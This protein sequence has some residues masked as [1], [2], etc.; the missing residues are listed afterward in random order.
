[1][2]PSTISQSTRKLAS[3]S[4]LRFLNLAATSVI[5]ILIMPFVVRMLGDRMYGVWALVATMIGYYGVL[6]FGLVQATSR[7]LASALGSGDEDE[8]NRVFNTG[9]RIYLA[10]GALVLLGA[11]VAALLA[12]RLTRTPEDASLFAR[13]IL[14]LGLSLA[15]QFPLRIF[16]GALEGHLRFDRTASLDMLALALRTALTVVVL[17]AGYRVEGLA[18]ST[19]LSYLPSMALTFHFTRRDLPFL[20]FDAKYWKTQTAKVLFSYSAYS[21][22]AQVAN[23]LRFQVDNLVVAGVVGLAA[24]TH[25]SVGGKLARSYMDAMVTLLGTFV[26]VFSRKEGAGD[27]EGLRK[28]FLFATRLSICLS[29]F[30]GFG[31]LVWGRPF[32]ARWMGSS[33]LDGYTCLAALVP[34]LMVALWQSPSTSLMFGI[35]KH[36]FL[37]ISSVIEGL[38]NLGLSIVLARKYGIVGVAL[39]TTFPMLVSKIFIQPFYVC[40]VADIAVIDYLRTVGRTLA[41]VIAAL[42]VPFLLTVK[43]VTPNYKMLFF[44]GGLS[45]AAYGAVLWM[46]E[47]NPVEA[48]LLRQALWP[49]LAVRRAG[50]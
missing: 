26:S 20:H 6:D 23:I 50:Q 3:G 36:R 9:L 12:P 14:I 32:I 18:W 33:Y 4:A 24:V 22:I 38:V 47:F 2:S 45:V 46:L 41:S 8:C 29:S 17:E 34:G 21:F 42:I 13:L 49:R 43:F 28:T 11:V 5:S 35:S 48:N 19:L 25:Y 27:F 39:G 30:V 7:Y 10:L 40:R 16:T 1:V 31:L 37:A 44:I 15:L